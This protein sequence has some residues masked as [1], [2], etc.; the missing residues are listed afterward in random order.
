MIEPN[1]SNIE[2]NKILLSEQQQKIYF[3]F[4]LQIKKH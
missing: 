4:T 1:V 3:F 2:K